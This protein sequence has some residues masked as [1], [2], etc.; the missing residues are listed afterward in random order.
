MQGGQYTREEVGVHNRHYG[1]PAV[2][3][4]TQGGQVGGEEAGGG[5]LSGQGED[6]GVGCD[7]DQVGPR[8]RSKTKRLRTLQSSF[9]FADDW[10]F[11]ETLCTTIKLVPLS[12]S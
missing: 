2:G 7:E 1:E 3:Q 4:I 8:T 9:V 6:P 10:S 12:S 5:G 11:H